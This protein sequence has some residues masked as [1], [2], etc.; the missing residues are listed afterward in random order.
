M[1][2]LATGHTSTIGASGMSFASSATGGYSYVEP[3]DITAG[4]D[5]NEY[6][7][8]GNDQLIGAWSDVTTKGSDPRLSSQ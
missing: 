1:M 6:E 3:F 7:Y 4:V 2:M 8:E 5:N